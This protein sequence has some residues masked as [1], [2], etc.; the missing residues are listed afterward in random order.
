VE[1]SSK[2]LKGKGYFVDL[3]A[4]AMIILKLNLKI[5]FEGVNWVHL[6]RYRNHWRTLVNTVMKFWFP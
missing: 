1:F 6:A 4:Y 2:N 3:G 5:G